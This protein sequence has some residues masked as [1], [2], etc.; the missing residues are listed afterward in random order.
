M[1]ILEAI[2][3]AIWDVM[4]N[5]IWEGDVLGDIGADDIEEAIGEAILWD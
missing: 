3:E 4:G 1:Q 5:V 2:R